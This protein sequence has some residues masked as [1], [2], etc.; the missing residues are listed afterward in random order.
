M[1]AIS[2]ISGICNSRLFLPSGEAIINDVGLA[3]LTLLTAESN[4]RDKD[5]MIRLTMKYA[6]SGAENM[7]QG[8]PV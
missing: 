3:A 6:D 8:L 7:A 1:A 5:V 2:S 4:L